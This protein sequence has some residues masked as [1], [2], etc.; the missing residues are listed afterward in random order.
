MGNY[1]LEIRL[2]DDG[3][4]YFETISS[5]DNLAGNTREKRHRR[6]KKPRRSKKHRS[7]K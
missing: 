1:T 5:Y 6:S 2:D 7:K 4:K 3:N